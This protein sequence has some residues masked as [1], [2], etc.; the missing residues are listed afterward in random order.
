VDSDLNATFVSVS[1]DQT[2]I[3]HKYCNKTNSIE[4]MNVGK[5]HARSV[6]CVAVD[7]SKKY[8]ATGSFDATL[9]IWS[10][11]LTTDPE[12]EQD[13]V[14]E[15]KKAKSS[16]EAPTRTPLITLAGTP[17]RLFNLQNYCLCLLQKN[18]YNCEKLKKILEKVII[19]KSLSRTQRP[20]DHESCMLA[21]HAQ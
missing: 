5:G 4:G 11:I 3:L 17:N 13:G 2:V 10:A 20:L 14:S 18:Y 16:K 21:N 12:Q 1:H 6:D 9:K 8:L 15:S 19:L 7:P